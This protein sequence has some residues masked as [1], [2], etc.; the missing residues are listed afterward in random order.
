MKRERLFIVANRLPV[1]ITGEKEDAKIQPA[2]G[3]LVTAI[4]SYLLH[5]N[6]KYS[7]IFWAGVPGCSEDTWAEASVQLKES[8]FTYL[9]VLAEK[10]QYDKYYNGF[11][12]SVLWPLFHYFPTY[13]EYNLDQYEDYLRVNE[14]FAEVLS[15][16]CREGDTIWIHDYHLLPLAGMLRKKCPEIKIGFFLHIPF[17]S[18]EVF[19]L[20]PGKWQE[21]LL[22][23]VLGADLIGFHTIDYAGHFQ[24]CI[25]KVLL[26]DHESSIIRYRQRVVKVGVFPIS[27]DYQFFHDA[28]DKK[29]VHGIRQD[30]RKKMKGSK[31]IFSVDRLDYTKGVHNRLRAYDF[32][33]QQHP[34]YH[35]KVVFV[36]N[37]IPSRDQIPKYMERKQMIDVLI[38]DINSRVG[39]LHWQP[40]IYRY[41][42]MDF[43]EMVALYS[44]CDVALITPL[45]DGMNLVAKEFVASRKDRRGV[46]V[47]SEMAGAAKELTGA[48]MIN[49]ND[50]QEMGEMIR[51]GLEMKPQEQEDRMHKMQ[52]RLARYDVNA[53]AAD[54]LKTLCIIT[55]KQKAKEGK[56]MYNKRQTECFLYALQ[57]F[58][59]TDV[60]FPS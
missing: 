16:Q 4:R 28:Y 13:A 58:K 45:R 26:L 2:S 29:E 3:G 33:L 15:A 1:S 5:S 21:E 24:E 44:I 6:N 34:E 50:I 46:L 55:K 22:N 32:F 12:N 60:R 39:N 57:S 11:S 43:D 23:G 49:P 38:S 19:R 56:I 40:V 20:M 14:Q 8:H 41:N 31:I 53:W 52:Q 10:D 51:E 47:L 42:F 25:Q 7:D 37:V 48:L 54:F 35:G 59:M 18:Y 17:P 9:P 27:I 36:I 30:L